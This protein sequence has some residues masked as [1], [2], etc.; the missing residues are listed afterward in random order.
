DSFGRC[1]LLRSPLFRHVAAWLAYSLRVWVIPSS[2]PLRRRLRAGIARLS[3]AKRAGIEAP[4]ALP[5]SA[6]RRSCDCHPLA[7]GGLGGLPGDVCPLLPPRHEP[8]RGGQPAVGPTA[9]LAR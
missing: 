9:A 1:G 5:R 7:G 6:L 8:R 3:V 4:S 2:A